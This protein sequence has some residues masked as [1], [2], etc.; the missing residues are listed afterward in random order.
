MESEIIV[1]AIGSAVCTLLLA[2]FIKRYT[3]QKHQE[4]LHQR[5]EKIHELE[6]QVHLR[7]R[8]YLDERNRIDLAHFDEKKIARL[9]AFEEGRQFGRAE[10]EREHVSQD[11]ERQSEFAS[12]LATEREQAA[13]EARER[14]R[15]E[16]ELQSKLFSV[17]I[18]P[19]VRIN[20]IKELFS[21]K[22]ETEVGYQY[23]LLINGIPAFQPHIIIE[24]S[25]IRKEVNE[26]NVRELL[27]VAKQVAE[28]AIDMYLGANGQFAKLAQPVIKRLKR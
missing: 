6:K 21:T 17:Q 15:A 14:L 26:E 12:K 7:E 8:E 4:E 28:G 1:V 19:F 5:D 24:R 13:A 16:Y 2:W 11:M 23:Q 18:S 10:S 25:E 20:E 27:S 3:N 9:N 22:H